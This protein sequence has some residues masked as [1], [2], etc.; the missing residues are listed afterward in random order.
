MNRV[1]EKVVRQSISLP[2][3]IARRVK[4]LAKHERTSA[5]RVIIDLIKTGLEARDREKQAFFELA[6]RLANSSNTAEQK[7]LKE[8]LARMT[9]GE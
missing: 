8:E 1:A 2:S 9:F 6:E 4:T 5:N 3:G 7:R